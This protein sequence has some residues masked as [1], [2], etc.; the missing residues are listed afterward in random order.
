MGKL[1]DTELIN[2]VKNG[3]EGAFEELYQRYHKLA[4][5]FANKVC[6]NEADAK[7]AVQDSFIEIHRSIH[8]LKENSFFKAWMYK[9]VVSKC[10]KIFRKN[11]F[12]TND[13]ENDMMVNELR[14]DRMEYIP[15]ASMHFHSDQDLLNCFIDRLPSAQ[16]SMIVLFYLEQMSI[17]EISEI[18]ELPVGTVKSRL[19]YARTYL[20]KE[21]TTYSD[22]YGETLTFQQL[23]A[24]VVG[25]LTTA[26]MNA[27]PVIILP[28]KMFS[29]KMH[30]AMVGVLSAAMIVCGV[31]T[32]AYLSHEGQPSNETSG[33]VKK[34][35][36]VVLENETI[37]NAQDAYFSLISWAC[38]EEM[39]DQKSQEELLS[40]KPLYEELKH[41]GGPFYERLSRKGWSTI[42]EKKIN[43]K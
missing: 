35:Q 18:L 34:F 1:S 36:R 25:A 27:K 19:S 20:K 12:V 6:K 30:M 16:R 41:F 31:G 11:K 10:K 7:D 39:M 5:F 14:E 4:Y 23:D 22:Q 28:K 17:N 8:T 38:C 37:D 33:Q 9:I 43:F 3:N 42:Y 32:Y 26:L 21:L 15:E 2:L 13:F 29:S 24:L 40:K